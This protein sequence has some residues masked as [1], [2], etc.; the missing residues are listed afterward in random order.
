ME[1]VTPMGIS[2]LPTETLILVISF[3]EMGDKLSSNRVCRQWHEVIS[4]ACLYQKR[5]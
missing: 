1:T 3:L 5:F 4:G 2:K